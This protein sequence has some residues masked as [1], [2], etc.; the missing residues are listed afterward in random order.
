MSMLKNFF[1]IIIVFTILT[2]SIFFG[3]YFFIEKNPQ[4]IKS[5]TI[6]SF[7]EGVKDAQ[8]IKLL[9]V[10]DIMLDRT[11]RKDGERYGYK[12]LFACLEEKFSEYDLVIG[13]LEGTV[14]DY[15]S[16]SRDARYMS[17][18]SFRFTFD[19]EAVKALRDIGLRVVSLVNNHITD[20]GKEGIKQT[21]NNLDEIGVQHFGSPHAQGRPWLI[22]TID[23]TRIVFIPYNE[24]SGTAD[25]T[26]Q[27]LKETSEISDIQIV[28]A[29]WGAEYVEVL[30][31]V[32]KLAKIFV[33]NGADLIIGAHPHVIQ[34]KEI[35]NSVPIY[36][37]LGNFIFDQYFSPEVKKG[38]AVNVEILDKS[39]IN[40][41]ELFVLSERKKGTCFQNPI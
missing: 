17:P 2:S 39:I 4:E 10:G 35:Y 30:P 24:F 5:Q 18:E 27:S 15:E 26:I 12:N 41:S 7:S 19:I 16:V 40:T 11:I 28:F 1:I 37:S 21:V 38:L 23:D 36:Y 33:D 6:L 8:S 25:Q 31:S 14:T 22:R 34:E 32:K 29:H 3:F 13:N 20:F 9:F